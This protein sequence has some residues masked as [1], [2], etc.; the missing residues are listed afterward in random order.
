[1]VFRPA[2]GGAQ[3]VSVSG[4]EISKL[5]TIMPN[6]AGEVLNIR[7]ARAGDTYEIADIQGRILIKGRIDATAAINVRVLTDGN[8]FLRINA[9]DGK[10][11][12][13]T[14]AKY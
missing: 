8:Y 3:N 14:F 2:G 12:A 1:M 4:R 11:T 10:S 9:P 13:F 6:P 7:D 5:T